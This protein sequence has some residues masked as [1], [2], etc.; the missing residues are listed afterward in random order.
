MNDKEKHPNFIGKLRSKLRTRLLRNPLREWWAK[1]LRTIL[2]NVR[3]R[4]FLLVLDLVLVVFLLYILAINL[5]TS[6]LGNVLLVLGFFAIFLYFPITYG[7]RSFGQITSEMALNGSI[8]AVRSYIKHLRERSNERDIRLL[9]INID[10]VRINLKDLISYSNILSPPIYNYELDRVQKG[11]DI[12]FNSI[13]E[14]LFPVKRPFSRAQKIE[15]QETLDYY[16]SQEHPT[17]EEEAEAYEEAQRHD[18]GEIDW[19]DRE[20]L[21]EFMEYLGDTLFVKTE[22]YRPFSYRHPI[23]LIEISGFFKT[24]NSLVLYCSKE[25]FEKTENDIE[26]YYKSVG[27]SKQRMRELR[28]EIL[29]TI[30]PVVLTAI[31]TVA[32]SKLT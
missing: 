14:M 7:T 20:T 2:S 5:N 17:E 21:D 13:S 18:R 24:W 26:E 6:S 10:G 3:Y 4:L 32:L 15:Q 23:N 22:P 29:I 30:V 16:E 25:I 1:N 12:F 31:L 11:I 27:Q 8:F 28:T 9:Q 19:F